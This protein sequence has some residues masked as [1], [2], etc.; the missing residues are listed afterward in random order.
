MDKGHVGRDATHVRLVDD[1]SEVV[2]VRRGRWPEREGVD[3]GAAGRAKGESR[4]GG[5]K[6]R[7]TMGGFGDPFQV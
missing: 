3:D 5:G 6:A 7:I 4:I 2:H 1:R